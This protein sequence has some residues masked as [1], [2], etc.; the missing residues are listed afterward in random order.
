MRENPLPEITIF[1]DNDF[2]ALTRK[3][4][5]LPIGNAPMT[6]KYRLDNHI[7]RT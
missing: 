7:L 6:F 5:N 3:L 4:Q 2:A 1:S